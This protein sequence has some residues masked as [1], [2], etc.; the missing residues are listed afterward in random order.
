MNIPCE[1]IDYKNE[2]EFLNF[3]RVPQKNGK[4]KICNY[5]VIMNEKYGKKYIETIRYI[6]CVFG[7]KLAVIIYIQ[8]KNIKINKKIL[9]NPFIHIV[10]TYSEKD[11]LNYYNDSYIRLKD[12]TLICENEQ[13][14]KKILGININFPKLGEVKIIREQ[15]NGWDM[16]KDLNANF[17]NLIKVIQTLGFIDTTLFNIDI[18]KVYK[19]N[20]CPDL[21]I[22]HYGNYFSGEYLIEQ[23]IPILCGVKLFLYAYTLEED[24][25]KKSFYYIMN[26]DFRS[27]DFQ[28]ISRYLPMIYSIYRL[29]KQK[30]LNSYSGNVYRATCFKKELI[31]E[32]QE[33]KKMLNVSLWSSSKKLEVAERFLFEDKNKSK[34]VL[35]HAKLKEGCNIDIHLEKISKY[36]NEEEVLILPFCFFE[37]KSFKKNKRNNLEYYYLE[38]IYCEEDN[39]SNKIENVKFNEVNNI[40]DDN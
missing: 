15:D 14:T 35:L 32:I 29:L 30:H 11:I 36:P 23:V 21:F 24:N 4:F 31:N 12:T 6:S 28:K 2:N 34:N 27:G 26:N 13:H 5:F 16:V 37:V 7:I 38:L 1:N 20:N 19:E 3:F 40:F 17:F 22:N 33:G 8:N 10:L 39:K 9:E 18:Y 25:Y